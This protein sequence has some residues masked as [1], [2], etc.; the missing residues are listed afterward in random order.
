M[1]ECRIDLF[2]SPI[3]L[4]HI[5]RDIAISDCL[6]GTA[7]NFVTGAGAARMLKETGRGVQ[8]VYRPPP[9]KVTNGKLRGQAR[10]LWDY[11]RYYAR[12][13]KSARDIISESRP[14]IV[15]SDE[16]FA[17][18]AVAQ[19]M[20]IPTV[21]IT[22]ILETRFASGIAGMIERKMNKSMHDIMS[23]CDAVILPEEGRD[24]GNMRR[25]GPIVRQTMH[26]RDELREKFG[27]TRDTILVSVGGTDAGTFL[28]QRAIDAAKRSGLGA[29]VVIV[30]GPA[31]STKFE[32]VRNMG[33]VPNMHE[34]VF[35]AD[36]LVSTAG[37][38]T[39]DEAAAYGTPAIFI[40]IRG[41]F[42][43]EDNARDAGFSHTDLGR[44]GGLMA[45]KMGGP[46]VRAGAKG[47]CRA[48]HTIM[49]A[50]GFKG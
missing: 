43:Q 33:F 18:L 20:G 29:D 28:I 38:S 45:S 15:V 40:P 9:F 42:E 6:P 21:L 17:S 48:A 44:L 5:T 27:F 3:G 49:E 25:V 34:L 35:A 31:I 32:G 8:D 46:R 7:V 26:T 10:W 16:D 30:Q 24:E 41:H 14:G 50:A 4:G 39:M 19:G 12:C 37:K 22:D 11:Y 13:K 36:L 2:S 23:R 1:A 47:A